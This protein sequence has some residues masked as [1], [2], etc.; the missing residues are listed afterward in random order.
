MNCMRNQFGYVSL[1]GQRGRRDAANP[2]WYLC[3]ISLSVWAKNLA[4][5]SGSRDRQWQSQR[6]AVE[7]CAGSH[8][9]I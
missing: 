6:A 1:L 7:E 9:A 4:E 8:L 2:Y 3:Q 5:V